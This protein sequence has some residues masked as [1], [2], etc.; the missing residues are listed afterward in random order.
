MSL[1]AFNSVMTYEIAAREQGEAGLSAAEADD[2]W[3]W[4]QDKPATVR[5]AGP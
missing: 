1:W 5:T 3:A 4:M 2:I